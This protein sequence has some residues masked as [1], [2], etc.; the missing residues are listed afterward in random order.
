VN[1]NVKI[2]PI[3]D[4]G[5]ESNIIAGYAYIWKMRS[6][7]NA[8]KGQKGAFVV[9]INTSLGLECC[10][11]P[12]DHPLWCA[13]YDSLGKS[14]VLSVCATLNE[15]IN[16]D[17]RGDV[18][19]ACSS[20]F[21]ISVTNTEKNGKKWAGSGFGKTAIDLGAPGQDTYSTSI[22]FQSGK[23][24]EHYKSL[25]GTSLAT[26]HVSGSV[27]LIYSMPCFR[28]AQDALSA[29]T[30]AA[31][32]VRDLILQNTA[33]EPTLSGLTT[34]GGRLDLGRIGKSVRELCDGSS[35]PLGIFSL[36]P[37]PSSDIVTVFYE[38][39]DFEP[40]RFRVF[41]MLG[42]L[43]FEDNLKPEQFGKKQYRFDAGHL[44][45]GVY[46][47]TIGRGAVIKS[48]KFVRR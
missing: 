48:A 21:M 29:P 37:N 19:S 9:T 20:E 44:P 40:Y 45:S 33:P 18:P 22:R 15:S 2:M 32:R 46:V 16:V 8:S 10:A 5:N 6:L 27:A 12:E 13:A 25:G 30:A 28:I 1:W 39:P 43:L 38:T 31:K 24:T 26:P 42:R 35:G 4:A 14:G 17:E 47:I 11:K 23:P 7:Y 36:Q 3:T 41:D 34:T